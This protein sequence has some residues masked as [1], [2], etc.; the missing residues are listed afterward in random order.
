MCNL[1]KIKPMVKE[2]AFYI[3]SRLVFPHQTAKI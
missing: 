2:E 3:K 1:K